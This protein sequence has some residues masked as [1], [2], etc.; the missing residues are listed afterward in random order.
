MERATCTIK[1]LAGV[2]G[3]AYELAHSIADDAGRCNGRRFNSRKLIDQAQQRGIRFRKLRMGSHTLRKF[4]REH[5][6]GRYF[7]RK[8]GHA[9][10]VIDGQVSDHTR[11]GSIV[12]DAWEATEQQAI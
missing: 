10:A 4:I 12:L 7:M 1:A 11:I 8:R 9:F 5:P 2:A 3:I 6:T